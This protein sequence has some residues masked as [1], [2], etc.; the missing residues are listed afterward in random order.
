MEAVIRLAG[1]DTVGL[2]MVPVLA[3]AWV[4]SLRLPEM[5]ALSG[6]DPMEYTL[7][8]EGAEAARKLRIEVKAQGT[9]VGG[10]PLMRGQSDV[11]MTARALRESD[12]ENLRKQLLSADPQKIRDGVKQLEGSAYRIADAIYSAE[13]K[14]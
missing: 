11:W 3:N 9:G 6:N 14:K 12:L 8:T 10:E 7:M 5:R 2:V 13:A 4:R 1:S